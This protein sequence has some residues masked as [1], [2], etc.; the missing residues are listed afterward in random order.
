M[1]SDLYEVH[2]MLGASLNLIVLTFEIMLRI[3]YLYNS[4]LT[5]VLSILMPIKHK[6]DEIRRYRHSEKK[7]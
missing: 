3:Y 2:D 1:I 5:L 6:K 4:I 7:Y